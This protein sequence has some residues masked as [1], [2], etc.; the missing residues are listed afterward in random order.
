MCHTFQPLLLNGPVSPTTMKKCK[1]TSLRPRRVFFISTITLF[2]I[3]VISIVTGVGSAASSVTAVAPFCTTDPVVVNNLDSGAGS[4]RQA[5][6]DACDG[7]TITFD[8]AQVTS[9]I[10]LSTAELTINKNL[11]ITGPG[12]GL[13][14]IQRSIVIA[15]P[16]FRI[17]NISISSTDRKSVV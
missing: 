6:A 3:L 2:L 12:S 4:L 7:S 10:S 8:M 15:T 11:T 16:Q 9:P 1:S 14:K 5:I 13:L 17:F